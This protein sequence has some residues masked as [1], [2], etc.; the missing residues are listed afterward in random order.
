M[1]QGCAGAVPIRGDLSLH[2]ERFTGAVADGAA[3]QVK[4]Q[5]S[6]HIIDVPTDRTILQAVHD[7]VPAISVGCE[8]CLRRLP[9]HHLPA[10][11]RSRSGAA[12]HPSGCAGGGANRC[13]HTGLLHHHFSVITLAHLVTPCHQETRNGN[14]YR[15][16]RFPRVNCI[17]NKRSRSEGVAG[18]PLQADAHLFMSVDSTDMNRYSGSI[19]L[20]TATARFIGQLVVK[21]AYATVGDWPS[22]GCQARLIFALLLASNATARRGAVSMS[23]WGPPVRDTTCTADCS[24][25]EG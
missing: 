14:S 4:L 21:F 5:R 25:P 16:F 18:V 8:R 2:G 1:L 19:D 3:F 23:T 6:R 17:F 22:Y 7:V 10:V 13:E 15:G 12:C 9:R 24:C 11:T 20:P